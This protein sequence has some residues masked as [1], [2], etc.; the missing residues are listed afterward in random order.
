MT[1]RKRKEGRRSGSKPF[2]DIGVGDI[3]EAYPHEQH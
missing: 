2:K 1:A 3:V